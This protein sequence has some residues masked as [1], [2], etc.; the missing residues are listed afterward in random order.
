MQ[1]S[2]APLSGLSTG[3]I[4]AISG[5]AIVIVGWLVQGLGG[6][7]K[8]D[9]NLVTKQDD[10]ILR[11][12]TALW[13]SHEHIKTELGYAKGELA[14]LSDRIENTLPNQRH[15]D[16]KLEAVRAHLDGKLDDLLKELKTTQIQL[17]RIE[18]RD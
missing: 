5:V 18:K 7:L 12:V 6:L 16:T 15:W 2:A 4:I 11:Q 9:R 14:V 13:K 3:E 10:E 1:V 8:H 17:A